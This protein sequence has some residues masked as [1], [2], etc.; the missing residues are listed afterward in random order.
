MDHVYLH[1]FRGFSDTLV[2][3]CDVNFLAGENSTG[4]TSF[5][6]VLK[7]LRSA[8]FWPR[9][10]FN[11]EDV[12]FGHFDDIF[13]GKP[14]DEA[15]FRVGFSSSVRNDVKKNGSKGFQLDVLEF[16]NQN[17]RPIL[18]RYVLRQGSTLLHILWEDGVPRFSIQKVSDFENKFDDSTAGIAQFLKSEMRRTS[19]FESLPVNTP[20]DHSHLFSVVLAIDNTEKLF[21]SM[22]RF[23]PRFS[24]D[25][26]WIAPIRS[27]PQRTYDSYEKNYSPE[28]AHT[29]YVLRTRLGRASSSRAF[30]DLLEKFGELSGLFRTVKVK[31]YG[32]DDTAPFEVLIVLTRKKLKLNA[33]GYGVSQALPVVVELLTRPKGAEFAIQQPE[34]HLHPK[35]QAALGELIW[36]LAHHQGKKFLIETHSDF[37]IDSFRFSASAAKGAQTTSQVLFFERSNSGNRIYS[38]PIAHDGSFSSEQPD[39]F[40][41]FFINE[42]LR[43]LSL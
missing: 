7:L 14:E 29:P 4:K 6:S 26:V 23:Q 42:S 12:Q 33:V 31:E 24:A 30:R 43:L 13:S 38:I 28:G 25:L 36:S 27:K 21:R 10:E 16:R 8:S 39:S 5:L 35:A 18:C 20:C 32:K 3:L 9:Q 34:V 37:L 22:L 2:P 17:G 41:N 19:G 15:K 1:N 11:T 40:R